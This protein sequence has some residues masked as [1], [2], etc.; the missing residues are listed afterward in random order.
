[1]HMP[2]FVKG[3]L[4]RRERRAYPHGSATDERQS[5][6]A[7][8]PP[9]EGLFVKGSLASLLAPHRSMRI[10]SSLAPRQRAFHK[11][12]QVHKFMTLCLV[13]AAPKQD[14]QKRHVFPIQLTPDCGR[15]IYSNRQTS[16]TWRIQAVRNCKHLQINGGIV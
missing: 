16:P 10:G 13:L 4:A 6:A 9:P 2:L 5:L 1:M 14:A 12:R 11:Q 8:G 15:L 7:K 3:S